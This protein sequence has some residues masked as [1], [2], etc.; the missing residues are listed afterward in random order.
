VQVSAANVQQMY[1]DVLRNSQ[2]SDNI[3]RIEPSYV[4]DALQKVIIAA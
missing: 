3:K 1:D 4:A 2:A